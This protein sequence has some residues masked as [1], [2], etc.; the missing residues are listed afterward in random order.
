MFKVWNFQ[1]CLSIIFAILL[2]T[3]AVYAA[4]SD[5]AQSSAKINSKEA[6]NLLRKQMDYSIEEV[7]HSNVP[8]NAL[9]I[10][11]L[12]GIKDLNFDL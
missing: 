2:S 7:S 5:K 4:G 8:K 11:R 3:N 9:Q 10:A 1:C 12:L 6:L